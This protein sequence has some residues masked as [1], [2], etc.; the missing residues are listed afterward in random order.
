MHE[1]MAS[2]MATTKAGNAHNARKCAALRK[3]KVIAQTKRKKTGLLK[4]YQRS[5]G[6][7]DVPFFFPIT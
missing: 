4:S 2:P 3:L 6:R 1:G 5:F 7:G